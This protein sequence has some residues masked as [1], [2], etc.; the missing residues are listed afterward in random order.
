[1]E[2]STALPTSKKCI[3]GSQSDL[4]R[5]LSQFMVCLVLIYLDQSID[6][7]F[8][9]IQDHPV[10]KIYVFCWKAPKG[11]SRPS[12]SQLQPSDSI[13][14]A[15]QL[16]HFHGAWRIMEKRGSTWQPNA[17]QTIPNRGGNCWASYDWD[18]VKISKMTRWFA[19]FLDNFSIFQLCVSVS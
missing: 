18:D 11:G 3:H 16:H 10:R 14:V 5:G 13:C 17:I 4:Q 7:H 12:S 15:Q 19:R 8:E 2:S 6:L 9:S 1:M